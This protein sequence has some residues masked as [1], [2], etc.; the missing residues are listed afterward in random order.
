MLLN[1]FFENMNSTLE[2][3][4][5][6]AFIFSLYWF[7]MR[8][9]NSLGLRMFI[10]CGLLF[11]A[12]CV[13]LYQDEKQ[14]TKTL[15]TG[16]VYTATIV[17]KAT[18]GNNDH[19]VSVAFVANDGKKIRSST[20]EYVSQEEWDRF[21]T[22]KAIPVIYVPSTNKIFVQESTMRFKAEKIYL[23]Y[24]SGF[25]LVLGP[26]LYFWLRKL[27]VKVDET[28]GDEWVE[29]EDGSVILDERKSR[30]SRAL[31]RANI[32]SKLAQ[33]VSR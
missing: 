15:S 11:V 20:T 6:G 9:Y 13:W 25:W 24:F 10:M 23:Y 19:E 33:A 32:L 14:L 29:R 21:E 27:K 3:V 18:V 16:E 31:K 2:L 5:I 1:L 17:S 30:T 28:T 4:L 12:T 22:G 26:V 8:K 7:I